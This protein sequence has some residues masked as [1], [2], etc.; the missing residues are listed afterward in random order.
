MSQTTTPHPPVHTKLPA[1]YIMAFP[2]FVVCWPLIAA[3]FILAM[4][5]GIGILSEQ[6]ASI[7]W[8]TT[9]VF[10]LIS[11][12]FDFNREASVYIVLATI[13]VFLLGVIATVWLEIPVFH[14]ILEFI[15]LVHF[16]ISADSMLMCSLVLSVCY[17]AMIIHTYLFNRWKVRPGLMERIQ[18]WKA[19][20]E[21]PVDNRHPLKAVFLD[22]LDRFIL[23]NGGHL[24]IKVDGEG[25]R[26]IGL[27]WGDIME[28]ERRLDEYE[29]T[30]I[31]I[32]HHTS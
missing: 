23:F 6:V 26:L 10:V 28:L 22:H 1:V 27:V 9:L 18:W 17:I 16:R 30:P 13:I 3:G 15:G 11:M 19:V 21:I 5:L 7:M 12:G 31:S 2:P 8:L 20:E 25:E 14:D 32:N 24:Q 4:M 29:T